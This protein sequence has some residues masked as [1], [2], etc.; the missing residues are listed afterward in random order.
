MQN[1]TVTIRSIPEDVWRRVKVEALLRKETVPD[2]V[3]RLLKEALNGRK[4]K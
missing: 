4:V 1:I 3:T 2:C